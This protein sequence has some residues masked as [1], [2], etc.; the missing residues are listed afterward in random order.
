MHL[1][2][3]GGATTVTG[4]QFLLDTGR[5]LLYRGAIDNFKFPGDPQHVDFLESA[6]AEFLSGKPITRQETASFG[7]AIQTVY[8]QLPLKP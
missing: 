6:I 1:T 5:R 7:C 8:Y 3:L 4:S 2:F